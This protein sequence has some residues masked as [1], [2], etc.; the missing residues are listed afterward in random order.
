M[1]Y[2]GDFWSSVYTITDKLLWKCEK[3][4]ISNIGNI[5]I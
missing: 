3:L 2:A 1:V 4:L 5:R